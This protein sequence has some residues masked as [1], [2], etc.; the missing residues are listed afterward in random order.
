MCVSLS[1]Q[2][3]HFKDNYKHQDKHNLHYTKSVVI[4]I[5]L[6]HAGRVMS[7]LTGNYCVIDT[8][9]ITADT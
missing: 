7:T 2:S 4:K 3:F 8:S 9:P 5:Y 1:P 6:K